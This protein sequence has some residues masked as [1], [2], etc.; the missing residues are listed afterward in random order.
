MLFSDY[1]DGEPKAK[2]IEPESYA[3]MSWDDWSKLKPRVNDET[4][5]AANMVF[6]CPEVIMLTRYDKFPQPKS[7]FS[8]RTLYKRDRYTCQ[9][10]GKKPGTESLTI[11]H[12]IPRSR[13]G[14]TTWENTVLA[15]VECNSKKANR[16]P[17]EAG[18]KLLTVPAK[19]KV[20]LF[21]SDFVKPVKS[22]DAFISTA[23]W[24]VELQD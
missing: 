7:H 20:S 1:E 2:V 10:C 13:G 18:M 14:L 8:R 11:D 3:M 5:R 6:R 19:P 4:I 17:K 23:Y 12:I 9:Y 24:E 16:T 15:C 21:K 22:W